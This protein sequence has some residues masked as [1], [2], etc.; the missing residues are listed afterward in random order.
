MKQIRRD[1]G[2]DAVILHSKSIYRGG[3]LGL[4]RKKGIEVIAAVDREIKTPAET[5]SES[6][7]GWQPQAKEETI[8]NYNE[9]SLLQ[10]IKQLKNM[11]QKMSDNGSATYPVPPPFK[12]IFQ[13]LENKI[14]IMKYWQN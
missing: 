7:Q 6:I 8:P 5:F 3:F 14:F 1:L 9:K 4:F 13:Y 11:M 10:E 2:S 12:T